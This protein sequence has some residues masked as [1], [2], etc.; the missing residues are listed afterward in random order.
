MIVSSSLLNRVASDP[1]LILKWRSTEG[2]TLNSNKVISWEDEI[3]GVVVTQ[4]TDAL[5]PTIAQSEF[6]GQYLKFVSQELI[7]SGN[8]TD[9]E[10]LSKYTIYIVSGGMYATT[11]NIGSYSRANCGVISYER[12]GDASHFSTSFGGSLVTGNAANESSVLLT[13]AAPTPTWAYNLG[14]QVSVRTVV[15][16][17]TQATNNAKHK[18]Y[19]S[20]VLKASST[21]GA[22]NYP[23]VTFSGGSNQ[24]QIGQRGTTNYNGGIFEIRVYNTDHD[25]TKRSSIYNSLASQYNL[26]G[27]MEWICNG[28]SITEGAGSSLGLGYPTQL[29]TLLGFDDH[30]VY[31]IGVGGQTA[32]QI[33]ARTANQLLAEPTANRALIGLLGTNDIATAVATATVIS[34]VQTFVTANVALG[35]PVYIM[36]IPAGEAVGNPNYDTDRLTVNAAIRANAVSSWGA[37]GVIDIGGTGTGLGDAADVGGVNYFDDIHPNNTGYAIIASMVYDAI[38]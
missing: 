28:D 33:N 19:S 37:T 34:R 21:I 8:I 13:N 3:L 26:S 23:S 25:S 15:W 31:N 32:S 18:I 38:T 5:R 7:Y 11:T 22:G 35:F 36:T 24:F 29:A 1:T 17:G 2:L 27:K 9:L 16:D 14:S 6:S 10:G 4:A 12:I 20:N 30:L